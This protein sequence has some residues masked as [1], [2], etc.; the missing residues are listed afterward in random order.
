MCIKNC[1]C[2][3]AEAIV[4]NMLAEL[5]NSKHSSPE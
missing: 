1:L 3:E 5:R 2:G 4:A